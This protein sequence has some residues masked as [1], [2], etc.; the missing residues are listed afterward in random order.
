[1]L[2]LISMGTIFKQTISTKPHP[3]RS[4]R[5][6]TGKDYLF[7]AS[8]VLLLT[9]ATVAEAEWQLTDIPHAGSS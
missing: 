7:A 1:M 4:A 5:F 6:I 9:F 2:H 8:V 3:I